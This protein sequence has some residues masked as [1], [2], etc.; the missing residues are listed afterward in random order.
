MNPSSNCELAFRLFERIRNSPVVKNYLL[1]HQEIIQNI[2]CITRE[3]LRDHREIREFV[4]NLVSS[5]HHGRRLP[6]WCTANVYNQLK[7]IFDISLRFDYT[8]E[9]E[10]E[11]RRL[12]AGVLMNEIF[13]GLDPDIDPYRS[14]LSIYVTVKN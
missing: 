2:S 13:K 8:G 1:L 14:R 7:E 6:K 9:I 12:R 3:N 5:K 10:P 4:D 11:L